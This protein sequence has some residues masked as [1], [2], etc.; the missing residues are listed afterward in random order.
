MEVLASALKHGVVTDD[1]LHC[2][3]FALAVD[4]VDEDPIRYL[5]LVPD[6]VGNLLELI[7]VDR[8]NGPCVIHAMYMREQYKK[9]LDKRGDQ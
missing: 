6:R 9:L 8:P 3:R 7:V 1:I 2:L 5:I 4:E